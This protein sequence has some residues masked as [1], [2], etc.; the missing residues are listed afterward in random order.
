MGQVTATLSLF[1]Q[2][3]VFVAQLGFEYAPPKDLHHYIFYNL[4]RDRI[5]EASF[6]NTERIEGAQIKYVWRDLETSKGVYDF[7][8]VREDLEFLNAHGKRLFIQLQD[9]SFDKARLNVPDYLIH[10]PE[11]HGGLARQGGGWMARRWDPAVQDRFA[12]LL[13]ALGK[14][15]DG[16]VEGLNFAETSIDVDSAS[17]PAGFTYDAYRDGIIANMKA[18]KR[19]FKRSTVMLYGNFMPGEWLPADDHGYLKS[20]Y[21]AAREL[22]VAVGGPDL[23]PNR[24]G[25]L[26]HSYPLI[27]AAQGFGKNGVAVQEGNY[28]LNPFRKLVDFAENYLGVHYVFWF[29]E[30]PYY[31]RDVLPYL[32]RTRGFD[33]VWNMEV[34][35]ET[36]DTVL[37]R[38][39]LR[40]DGNGTEWR[41]KFPDRADTLHARLLST[42]GDSIMVELGPYS[43]TL[44][45]GVEVRTAST[46]HLNNK[47]LNGRSTVRYKIDTPDSVMLV[48]TRGQRQR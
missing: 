43:S 47:Q 3:V 12:A 15:F 6:L 30:E 9:V 38:Y 33:G 13:S 40:I 42:A 41:I 26:N 22:G 7:S 8:M 25:Q 24:R 39:T 10:D 44:R 37:A 2:I 23:I 48:R 17:L 35:H 45:P 1:A 36:R 32:G 46:Y 11:Y 16:R 21:Q 31:S 27:R 28:E 14:E 5:H 19:A 29:P 18:A 4:A 34:L 20:V